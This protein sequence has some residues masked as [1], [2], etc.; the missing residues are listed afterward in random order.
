MLLDLFLGLFIMH[1][2]S[3]F[4]TFLF[5]EDALRCLR[6]SGARVWAQKPNPLV[7]NVV[8]LAIQPSR[9]SFWKRWGKLPALLKLGNSLRRT[10]KLLCW[11]PM[12]RRKTLKR[13]SGRR[14]FRAGPAAK[15]VQSK[16]RKCRQTAARA[17]HA[18]K[19]KL[20]APR[21]KAN[22]AKQMRV[23]K[24]TVEA[25]HKKLL[26]TKW[27]WMQKNCDCGGVLLACS[28]K[29]CQ[30]RGL[31]RKF[32]YCTGCRNY[33]DV[34]HWSHLPNV[35]MPLPSL[36]ETMRLYFESV[37]A[38]TAE[39]IAR[40]IGM[41][42]TSGS[43]VHSII[44]ALWR[45]E[46]RCW[47]ARQKSRMLHGV[48]KADA[49]SLRKWT[50]S[51][52]NLCYF[53]FWVSCKDLPQPS[54]ATRVCN[55][56]NMGVVKARPVFVGYSFRLW[57][58]FSLKA[59]QL[60]IFDFC[61]NLV[62]RMFPLES[63]FDII[64]TNYAYAFEQKTY[65]K[66]PHPY[67]RGEAESRP[68]KAKKGSCRRKL[69]TRSAWKTQLERKQPSSLMELLHI[70]AFQKQKVCCTTLATIVL[71]SLMRQDGEED[72]PPCKWIQVQ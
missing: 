46:I 10:R 70:L 6:K 9:K 62:W 51:S 35:R 47:E 22:P 41:S 72:S 29:H 12:E 37:T 5:N 17:R 45:H 39:D 4:K 28:F 58:M 60:L 7:R 54:A 69:W 8:K 71:E 18:E 64:P 50:D 25:A 21:P 43:P 15:N 44:D 20:R 34:M 52:N 24:K 61:C 38:P 59:R 3:R 26:Q 42:G 55:V 2:L 53:R 11:I 27:C 19:D 49:T 30:Q 56:Y 16:A 67:L 23:T 13:A 31:G 68:W 40:R 1:M 65:Q 57:M 33:K 66:R 32:V 36:A 63:S 48:V 14:H